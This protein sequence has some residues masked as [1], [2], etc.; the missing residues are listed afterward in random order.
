MSGTRGCAVYQ[1]S[2]SDRWSGV[3][4]WATAER[5]DVWSHSQGVVPLG[6]AIAAALGLDLGAVRVRHAENAGCYGH[7]AADDAA[8]DAVL[9]DLTVSGGM[10]GIEAVSY[11][12][13]LDPAVKLVVSTTSV[14]P[15]QWPTGSP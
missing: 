4:V 2:N 11:L 15:S 13:E 7:N 1:R 12:K 9:L 6:R 5:V 3:A 8:F 10:G 14:S